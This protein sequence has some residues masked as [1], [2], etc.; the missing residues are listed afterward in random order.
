MIFQPGPNRDC[1]CKF[2]RIE[3]KCSHANYQDWSPN[4]QN[5]S[6]GFKR[7]NSR[8]V[9]CV[10]VCH[11]CVMCVSCVSCVS[12][13]SCV[14]CVCHVCHVCHV[15]QPESAQRIGTSGSTVTP[16]ST[17]SS[18]RHTLHNICAPCEYIHKLNILRVGLNYCRM[19]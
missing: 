7:C 18:T 13:A 19:D 14:S 16:G 8:H 5:V 2:Q 11:V 10:R 15:T 6:K 3:M 9:S 17:I 1:M 4:Q 12:C